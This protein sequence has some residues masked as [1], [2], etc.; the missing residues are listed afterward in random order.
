MKKKD[1]ELVKAVFEEMAH[2]WNIRADD[3]VD[4]LFIIQHPSLPYFLGVR[5]E[6]YFKQRSELRGLINEKLKNGEWFFPKNTNAEMIE[7]MRE[8]IDDPI[9]HAWLVISTGKD[10]NI[11]DLESFRALRDQCL[12]L[13][14]I[15]RHYATNPNNIDVGVILDM[16]HL[17]LSLTREF[18]AVKNYW[19]AQ[20]ENRAK[21]SNR[22]K[23]GAEKMREMKSNRVLKIKEI[24][25]KYPLYKTDKK[26]RHAFLIE[27]MRETHSLSTRSID[28]YLKELDGG[29]E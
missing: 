20:M 2:L 14:K 22:G 15:Y 16:E 9:Q 25:S 29:A 7:A 17:S 12:F 1:I 24:I 23:P 13:S 21:M 8:T 28:N 26:Q 18:Y 4:C 27:A 6:S 5:G 10:N 19:K 11:D 3:L